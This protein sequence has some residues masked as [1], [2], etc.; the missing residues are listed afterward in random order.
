MATVLFAGGDER[1]LAALD[2]MQKQGFSTKTYAITHRTETDA[3][4]AT[5]LVLP[6]PCLKNGRLNAPLIDNPPTLEELIRETGID[7]TIPVIGGPIAENPFPRFI[8][9]SQREDLKLR[10]AVTTT[11]GAIDLLIRN[12]PR[13]I[14]A[15]P[16]LV[17]GYGAIG[18]RLSAMLFALG[19][20]VTVAARKQKDRTDAELHGYGIQSTD[21]LDLRGFSAIF[22]TVP[23]LLLTEPRLQQSETDVRIFELASAPGGCDRGAAQRLNR[24][25]IDGPA[26]PGKVAPVTAGEDLAKTVIHI[27]LSPKEKG[28]GTPGT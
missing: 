23:H 3:T 18:K 28:S 4:E 15:L 6:F 26:L 24:T 21:G 9:L 2:Y 19:A 10:N 14:L 1:T 22:N 8:D 5:A 17:I 27:L 7:Q 20:S 25:V 13:A 12:T 11:E 16:C